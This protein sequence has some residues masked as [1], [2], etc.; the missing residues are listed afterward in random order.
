MKFTCYTH[1]WYNFFGGLYIWKRI[2]G[3]TNK[4][5]TNDFVSRKNNKKRI[6]RITNIDTRSKNRSRSKK[7]YIDRNDTTISNKFKIDIDSY[8]INQLNNKYSNINKSNSKDSTINSTYYNS[9][10]SKTHTKAKASKYV[11]ISFRLLSLIIIVACCI[12]LFI[13]HQENNANKEIVSALRSQVQF[14]NVNITEETSDTIA[15]KRILDFSNLVS[16]NS[17]TVAWIEVNNTDVDFPVVKTNN[18]DYY[19][20]HNFE[21]KYNSAGWIFADYRNKLDGTDKNLI[22]YGHNRQD[23]SMFST[24]NNA[25]DK[26]W[27]TNKENLIITLYT[28]SQTQ[29]YEIF[30]VY[31]T[32]TEEFDN[33][34]NFKNDL[35]FENFFNDTINKSIYD[36]NQTISP[37]DKVLTLYTCANN[38]N[39]RILIHAKQIN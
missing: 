15:T 13:W 17:E 24:L 39:Y 12:R 37:D 21:K 30:S 38:T 6:S 27:Y 10:K 32:K 22:I 2:L 9:K 36:F 35:E 18:N 34:T 28:P 3:T 4:T 33:I 14:E 19:I 23:G 8:D 26:E 25:F 20:K 5:R 11:I 29:K 7:S 16:Q 31:K 1:L